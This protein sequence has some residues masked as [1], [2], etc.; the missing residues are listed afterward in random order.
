MG[1]AKKARLRALREVAH[2]ARL[3]AARL[4]KR[5][6]HLPQLGPGLKAFLLFAGW[7][8]ILLGL[9]GLVLPVLQGVLFLLLGAALLSLVSSSVYYGLRKLFA[10]WPRG[11][12]K[13]L[14]LRQRVHRWLDRKFGGGPLPPA[15]LSSEGEGGEPK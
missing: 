2:R 12:R 5:K 15:P 1:R 10:R 8:L 9:L 3:R 13:L 14:A 6:L 4:L 11:W 7:F